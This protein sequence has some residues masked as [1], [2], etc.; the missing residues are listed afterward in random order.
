[1]KT[2]TMRSRISFPRHGKAMLAL[3]AST[4]VCGVAGISVMPAHAE[5]NDQ[6]DEHQDKGGHNDQSRGEQRH[7]DQR[8]SD[9]DRHGYEQPRF[10]PQPVYAPPALYYP[11]QPSAG[12]T[13]FLPLD[14][15]I[16]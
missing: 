8:H 16:R 3:I 15:R 6:R 14:I 4:V 1:M 7:E 9:R 5:G 11:P 2:T 13:L 12:I 10:Y